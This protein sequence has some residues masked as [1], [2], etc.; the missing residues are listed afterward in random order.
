MAT[1]LKRLDLHGFKSFATPTTFVFDTGITA[2]IGPNGS[3]KSNISDA[4]RWVLGEQSYANLRGKRTEDIIFAGSS[5]RAPL[6]M[7]EVT[8]TLDNEDGSLPL[9][10][11]EVSVTRRAYRSGE[12]H[13]LLN[14]ARVRLKDVL[15]VTASLGQ[16]H[17][18]I[19]QGLVDA[20]LSQ[21][22]EERRSLFEHAA[23]ITGLRIKHASAGRNLEESQTN[24]VRLE[25]LLA[26]LEPRLRSLE[27]AARQAR[28]YDDVKRQLREALERFYA[29]HW[30]LARER[31]TDSNKSV[32]GLAS[33]I[34][35][36]GEARAEHLRALAH[37]TE[38]VRG[39]SN[40]LESLREHIQGTRDE[41][42]RAA[43]ELALVEERRRA[44]RNRRSDAEESL[45]GIEASIAEIAVEI[46]KITTSANEL[47][48]HTTERE[49]S[50][51]ALEDASTEI[52]RRLTEL[53]SRLKA[54]EQRRAE[55][56]RASILAE[57]REALI[58]GQIDQLHSEQERQ[59]EAGRA[60]DRTRAN[61]EAQQVTTA[62]ALAQAN[63]LLDA[64]TGRLNELLSEISTVSNER[65]ELGK[66]RSQTERK[67]LE[68]TTRF[69][70]LK[71]LE[72]SGVGLYAGV[73]QVLTA[74]RSNKIGG[75]LGTLASLLIVPA[76]LEAAI[77]AALGG[78][79]QDLV[80]ERWVNAEAAIE[81]LKRTQSGR[82]TFH[83]LD[84]VPPRRQ[85]SSPRLTPGV[86][87][88]ASELIGMDER[89]RGVIDGLLGRTLVA[90][91]L[92]AAR[93]ALRSLPPGWSVVT[94]GGEIARSSGTVTGGSRVKES[95]ALARERELR[96]LPK[97]R[98]TL[99]TERD[100]HS[101]KIGRLDT[102]L[103]ARS[104]DKSNVEQQLASLRGEI[105]DHTAMHG[106]QTRELADLKTAA[107]AESERLSGLDT[108]LAARQE[109]LA[110]LSRTKL[111]RERS[112]ANVLATCAALRDEIESTSASIDDVA[113]QLA[114]SELS[115]IRERARGIDEQRQRLEA[116]KRQ[117]ESDLEGSGRRLAELDATIHEFDRHHEAT[118]TQRDRLSEQVSGLQGRITQLQ[119]RYRE[120]A[121]RERSA[122]DAL[123][124]SDS[125]LRELERRQ[126]HLALEAARRRDELDLTIERAGRDLEIDQVEDILSRTTAAA[127]EDLP[128]VERDINRHRERLRRIGVAGD[129]AIEHYEREAERYGFLRRQ[130]DDVRAATEALR[131]LMTELDRTMALEFDRT[132][133]EVARAFES[134]F[135]SLFGGGKARLIRCDDEGGS[136]GIDIEAQPPGKRLQNLGLLSGGERA[137]TAVAL[138]FSILKVNPSP[139]CLLDEV[140]AA[141]DESNV[142][143][144]R[145]ELQLLARKTQFV[146]VTHNRSTIEGA[147]TLYGITMGDDGMSR[148]L[149]LRLPSGVASE[150]SAA[151]S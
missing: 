106:R 100:A 93:T 29:H 14:G 34:E 16:S 147:D 131:A 28:E 139:F 72:E 21:R 8:V 119:E 52:R 137:L 80:V 30:R 7:A 143:R 62:E 18:V 44:A 96:E 151:L 115:G 126:D 135:T 124:G 41:H 142:V 95:G 148:V 46:A 141:L 1:R 84:T 66:R 82:A 12:N 136:T 113:L 78:H 9:D 55:I 123:E 61:L 40:D 63:N 45:Q 144:V 48:R 4:L 109:E 59:R 118:V 53:D 64:Q 85:T 140:D 65:E 68:T 32:D 91:D 122:R 99:E 146:V 92:S 42:Q 86:R 38:A 60:R 101:E 111:D 130:L 6:G 76:E 24:C 125:A 112:L 43:H 73:K 22:V 107:A 129:D 47:R 97:L 58:R 114:R 103:V 108:A 49:E 110:E 102:S 98:V 117:L 25:D 50:L 67:V 57:S 39:L 26:D 121:Q 149:S 23:G 51:R 79:L 145:D 134:T 88:L 83:P 69:E 27:R 13:Y 71:R 87:G 3:G 70:T 19:G 56:E 77:E 36:A 90:E 89:V 11:S 138:L 150:A 104:Q 105:R 132:F 133:A 10:F 94:I 128:R 116:R 20:V 37:A 120:A 127:A 81:F 74:A 17:T 31:L 54:E 2:V 5:T 35:A 75:V 33:Q 15:Q